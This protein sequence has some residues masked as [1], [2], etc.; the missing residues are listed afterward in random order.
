M[1]ME[2]KKKNI[3]VLKVYFSP[4]HFEDFKS[5]TRKPAPGLFYLASKDFKINLD[6]FY[7][8]GTMLEIV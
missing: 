1:I 7:M 5:D 4:D 3:E 6:R 8:L 2:L